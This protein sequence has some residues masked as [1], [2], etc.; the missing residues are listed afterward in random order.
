M[1]IRLLYS[2]LI[3]FLF[4]STIFFVIS[5]FSDNEVNSLQLNA[6]K[7]EN[8]FFKVAESEGEVIREMI[9]M[10]ARTNPAVLAFKKNK[11][12]ALGAR[13][14][15]KVNTLEFLAFVFSDHDLVQEMKLLQES[16]I[17]YKRFVEA[18]LPK[19]LKEYER[20]DFDLRVHH[21]AKHLAIDEEKTTQ[22]FKECLNLAFSG[23]RSAFKS[24]IDYLI[25]A[26]I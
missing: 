11:L 25:V 2:C 3:L 18:L 7:Q 16:S 17:K 12:E 5:Y 19:L 26:K 1:K 21:F 13:L 10:M 15:G 22:I 9:T 23:E 24:L 20:G 14:R 4:G 8:N 6:S